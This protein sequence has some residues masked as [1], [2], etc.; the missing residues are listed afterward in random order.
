MPATKVFAGMT[1]SYTPKLL[2][3]L[4]HIGINNQLSPVPVLQPKLSI[5]KR[6][7]VFNVSYPIPTFPLKGKGADLPWCCDCNCRDNFPKARP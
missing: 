5:R 2:S 6:I 7:S 4:T 1:R 3:F